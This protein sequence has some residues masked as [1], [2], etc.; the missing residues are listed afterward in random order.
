MS[1]GYININMCG[2]IAA[3]H[4]KDMSFAGCG[5][6]HT[7]IFIPF[8]KS[9]EII[10]PDRL[11]MRNKKDKG[12]SY[13]DL[14]PNVAY[15][16]IYALSAEDYAVGKDLRTDI[17]V[18]CV[19]RLYVD[20]ILEISNKIIDFLQNVHEF[21]YVAD[22]MSQSNKFRNLCDTWDRIKY[23]AIKK[24]SPDLPQPRYH[25]ATTI[26]I[27]TRTFLRRFEPW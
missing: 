3:G 14:D 21:E 25:Y 15:V 27:K 6:Y 4:Y 23:D 13:I 18:H 22:H 24:V 9:D 17:R 10:S 1:S 16:E 20:D 12:I 19:R 8:S 11:K 7:R 26:D 2:F 5:S